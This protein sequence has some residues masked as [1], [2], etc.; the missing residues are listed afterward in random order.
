MVQTVKMDLKFSPFNQNIEVYIPDLLFSYRILH[1][2]D[3]KQSSSVLMGRQIR[4]AVTMSFANEEK[5]LY[6]R[7]KEAEPERTKF[8]LQKEQNTTVLE[9]I[10]ANIVHADQFVARFEPEDV[11]MPEKEHDETEEDEN[12]TEQNMEESGNDVTDLEDED[13]PRYRR[14][15]DR[16]R[17]EEQM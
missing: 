11:E 12:E 15:E 3:R 17:T 14:Y 13:R 8:I 5:V 16:H 7:N 2:A 6:K 4:A 9:K 10:A 1:H